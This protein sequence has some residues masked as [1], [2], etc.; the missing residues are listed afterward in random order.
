M[1]TADRRHFVARSIPLFLRQDYP[2]REL[3]VVDDGADPVAD[4]I[5]ADPRIRY[6]RPEVRQSIGAKR[7]RAAAAARG[8][9]LMCWDDDDWYGPGRITRQV[10]PLIRGTADASGFGDCLLLVLPAGHF[11]A[12]TPHLQ[13]RLFDRGIVSG[14]IAF[15]RELWEQGARFPDRSVG[16]DAAFVRQL[17]GRG[18]RLERLPGNDA[19]VYVRHETNTWRF[20]P[21][22]FLDPAGWRRAEAPG[23]LSASDRAFFGLPDEDRVSHAGSR[24]PAGPPRAD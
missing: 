15:R 10:L 1:P 19:F 8:S 5:P 17:S 14:T 13:Q 23:F 7:N 16:E 24:A 3:I 4:L 6:L 22:D 9:V 11:W 20:R 12:C 18:A 2:H 21:G